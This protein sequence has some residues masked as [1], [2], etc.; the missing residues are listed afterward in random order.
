MGQ[1]GRDASMVTHLGKCNVRL[2]KKYDRSSTTVT[3]PAR[4]SLSKSHLG[5]QGKETHRTEG[6]KAELRA[7]AATKKSALHLPQLVDPMWYSI[8]GD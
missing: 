8:G 5:N 6:E 1:P 2:A 3:L 4:L 7:R